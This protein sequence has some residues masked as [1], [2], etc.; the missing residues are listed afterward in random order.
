VFSPSGKVP[1]TTVFSLFHSRSY[2]NVQAPF[3]V[4]TETPDG[5]AVNFITGSGGFLQTI[6]AGYGGWR[7]TTEGLL[8]NPTLMADIRFVK[9]RKVHYLNG[10]MEVTF[11]STHL[12]LDVTYTGTP[13]LCLV[14]SVGQYDLFLRS[15]CHRNRNLPF[16]VLFLFLFLFLFFFFFFFLP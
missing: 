2:D 7:L 15:F 16:F 10:E 11:N 5:G 12:S 9:M 13:V 3:G 8:L 4:W 14:D 1:L 6:T